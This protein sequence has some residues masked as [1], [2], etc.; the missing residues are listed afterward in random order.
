MAR[1]WP[2]PRRL[3][4]FDVCTCVAW[5]LSKV[6]AMADTIQSANQTAA[7]FSRRSRQQT[8]W[9]ARGLVVAAVFL[10][11]LSLERAAAEPRV[12]LSEP[13]VFA[14]LPVG[15]PAEQGG[16]RAAGM[17]RADYGDG[18]RLV[19]LAPDGTAK[20][21]SGG[22]QS[23]CDP[24]VSF[25]GKRVLFAGK[26]AAGDRWNIYEMLAD[27]SEVR[28][29]TRDRG[30]CR[31]P[32]Y[33]STLYVLASNE[34]WYQITFVGV[35]RDTVNEI[36]SAPVS[37]LYSC[38]LDGTAVRR[39]TH[40][41]SSDIDPW[42]LPDG[43]LVFGAWQRS[44]L[45]RGDLGRITLWGVNIDGTDTALFAGDNG[46][47]RRV[48]HMPCAT[49]TLLV[50]VEAD[51]V[52][53]DGAGCLSSASLRRPLHSYQPLTQ[54]DDGLF[55]SPAPLPDGRLL[56]SWRPGDGTRG[57]GL[58]RFDPQTKRRE[59]VFDD[60][61]F[62]EIQA[63][64]L[65]PQEEPD[66]RGSVVDEQDPTAQL[67]CL[68]IGT[69]DLAEPD[70]LTAAIAKKVRVLEGIPR[71]PG[72]AAAGIPVL[73]QRR[74]IGEA[75]VETDGSFNIRIPASIPL[76]LQLLD[77]NGMALRSCSW[78]WAMNHEP[79]GCIGCHEDGELTPENWV[80][81]AMRH[82]S[83]PLDAPPEKRRTVDYRRDVAPIVEARCA[84]CHGEGEAEPRLDTPATAYENL[85]ARTETQGLEA[86][87]YIRP[88][89]ARTS[90]LVWHLYGRN[91]SRPWDGSAAAHAVK[92][93]PAGAVPLNEEEKRTFVE[94]I[95]LGALLDGPRAGATVEV[96]GERP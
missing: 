37:S 24:A 79:R 22:F 33:Q 77:E 28:Q 40:N 25:D 6:L 81:D 90:P 72:E 19:R 75:P 54:P 31:S 91:T 38:K 26:R 3:T 61:R 51:Q 44:T 63:R 2:A 48:K 82:P 14:Q 59:L 80:D 5:R 1:R 65:V 36:G 9:R 73:A 55:H 60:P 67:Y 43:R 47:G 96:K 95:D 50:F 11:L 78:I 41:L 83:V 7:I 20:V 10:G 69:H 21:L 85:L 64:C 56:V 52:P 15:S 66:G 32:G 92:P 87:R 71:K 89:R 45:E 53:W 8:V 34:P 94:W 70:W 57:H 68:D 49:A 93:I 29:I 46:L 4:Q 12:H 27:G 76:E 23:A 88:G 39:L 35:D 13:I 84:G 17:L 74:I 86:F 30:D 62:H 42:I 58:Y 16:A 18:A